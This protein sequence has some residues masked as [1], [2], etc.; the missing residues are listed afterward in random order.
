MKS[1][2]IED[3]KD[4]GWEKVYN[5]IQSLNPKD[6]DI[7]QRRSKVEEKKLHNL[8]ENAL[9]KIFKRKSQEFI[10]EKE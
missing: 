4:N 7:K 6:Y 5:F 8:I 10:Q 9:Q 2:F 3:S 1:G